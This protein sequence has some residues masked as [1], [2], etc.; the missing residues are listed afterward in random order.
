VIRNTLAALALLL[1]AVPCFAGKDRDF[2]AVVTAIETQYGVRHVHIP[3]LG[4]ATFCVR[5]AGVPGVKLAVFENVRG[6]TGM[7]PDSLE[8]SMQA[9]IGATWHPLVRVR[10]N[11][12]LTLIF[13]NADSK[14]LKALIVCLDRNDAT[15]IETKLSVSQ[16]Q[17][18]MHDPDEA[19]DLRH[20][21]F[22]ADM[23]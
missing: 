5:I 3:L 13:T 23:N 16:I 6:A 11:D 10:E 12:Q 7:S 20:G 2:H 4:F 1:L 22:F 9:A 19:R 17:R 15:V 8:D 21:E 18:W 14:K